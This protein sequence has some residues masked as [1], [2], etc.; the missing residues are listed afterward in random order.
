MIIFPQDEQPAET[1][2]RSE[3]EQKWMLFQRI[4]NAKAHYVAAAFADG[5]FVPALRLLVN[6]FYDSEIVETHEF[7]ELELRD[8]IKRKLFG[9]LR[10]V[11]LG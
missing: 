4:F 8:G 1:T 10:V 6:Y 11:E 7:D 3:L 5:E 2:S 9:D